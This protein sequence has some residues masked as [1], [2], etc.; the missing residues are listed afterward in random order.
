MIPEKQLNDLGFMKIKEGLYV[1]NAD[2]ISLY[3]DY[4]G[5]RPVSYAYAEGKRI[6]PAQFKEHH[7]IV[8]IERDLLQEQ[9]VTI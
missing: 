5:V 6:D 7:A 8:K 4:R 2:I 9:L 1:K 3:R